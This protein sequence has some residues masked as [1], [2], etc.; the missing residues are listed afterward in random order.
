MPSHLAAIGQLPQ[1][2]SNAR[3]VP[4]AGS[5]HEKELLEDGRGM[6]RA[7]CLFCAVWA[8]NTHTDSQLQYLVQV[9]LGLLLPEALAP[10]LL[11]VTVYWWTCSD[12]GQHCR[13][14]TA[15]PVAGIIS[16]SRVGV[17]SPVHNCSGTPN[18]IWLTARPPLQRK[19]HQLLGDTSTRPFLY[20][21][22]ERR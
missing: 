20:K 5:V 15:F 3:S 9:T 1:L 6:H 21:A 11:T 2:H 18:S 14:P 16:L 17:G 19:Y 10:P 4:W 8:Y 22:E 7:R 13:A 12:W